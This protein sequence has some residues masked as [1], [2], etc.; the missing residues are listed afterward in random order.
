[1]KCEFISETEGRVALKILKT[2]IMQVPSH[3]CT[4]Q[5]CT[6]KFRLTR[7]LYNR[8]R[9]STGSHVYFTTGYE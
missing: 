2:A 4:L 5:Q 8:L 7:I 1:M 3:T 9:V 6:S